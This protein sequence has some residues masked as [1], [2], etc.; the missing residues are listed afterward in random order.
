MKYEHFD[1]TVMVDEPEKSNELVYTEVAEGVLD[2]TSVVYEYIDPDAEANNIE[3]ELSFT[4]KPK[5]DKKSKKDFTRKR[6]PSE[7]MPILSFDTEYCKNP[8]GEGNR[9]LAYQ[10]VLGFGD[11]KN[12]IKGIIYPKSMKKSGRV[13]FDDFLVEVIE[14]GITA[15]IIDK[16]PT[17]IILCAHFLRADL[18]TFK[19]SF[20][21]IKTKIKGI[22][23]TV[24][25]LDKPYGVDLETVMKKRIDKESLKLWS[26][27][28]NDY[29]LNVTF[30]DTMLLA[31]AGYQS[32][33]AVGELVGV[34]KLEIPKPFSIERMDEYFKCDRA[35]AEEY[36]INDAVI[37]YL[38]MK[39][40]IDFCKELKLSRVPFT[41]GGLAVKAC[42]K[43]LEDG[44]VE[45]VKGVKKKD[46]LRLFGFV[47]TKIE[48]WVEREDKPSGFI[49]SSHNVLTPSRMIYEQFAT[50]TYS[51]GRGE[52][53]H[54]GPTP[55]G[56]FNDFDIQSC[57]T[58]ILNI[59]RPLNYDA[60][61]MSKCVSDYFGD[62]FGLL[63]VSFKFPKSVKFPS[64][65]V[66][67]EN[68]T[69]CFP[70]CGLSYCTAAE[71]EVAV[72]LDAEIEIINGIIIPW[73]NDERIFEPFMMHVR[74]RRRFYKG[75]GKSFEEKLW[76]EIGNSLYG[77]LAQGL[78]PKT[79]FDV[80]VGYSKQMPASV[81][82]NPYFAS[83]VTGMARAVLAEQLN[84]IPSDK[85]VVSVTTDGFLT[86][87]SMSD[88]DLSGPACNR[89]RDLFHL[90]DEDKGDILEVKHGATQL[91]GMKTRGQLTAQ[92]HED[93][94]PVIAKANV[95]LPQDV[96]DAHTYMVDLYLDR[97]SG[98]KHEMKMLTSS[99]DMF[100]NDKDLGNTTIKQRLNL[101][102]DYKRR[103]TNPH[104]V[105][106][107]DGRE[108]IALDSEPFN[109]IE[110]QMFTRKRFDV[111]RK[112]KC[113]KT[114]ADWDDW[115]EKLSMYTASK[116]K[117]VRIQKGETS[118]D[119]MCRLFLRGFAQKQWGLD[120]YSLTSKDLA[121][122]FCSHEYALTDAA[123]RGAKRSKLVEGAIPLTE[124]TLCLLRLL[125]AKFPKFK[126][127]ALFAP[128]A[129]DEL[130]SVMK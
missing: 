83:I 128:N 73:L 130:K 6:I 105:K 60:A 36:A 38:H 10:Y 18:F 122:W 86:N 76:K 45:R 15:K 27:S 112:N 3:T 75:S 37:S 63:R 114:I 82:T 17:D 16:W 52:N 11:L 5:L 124:Q 120:S 34:S 22:R 101:E 31:P 67:T 125:K 41:L 102:P 107:A 29:H 28:G 55:I 66:R 90:I 65:P 62:V 50:E 77:K 104:I 20:S 88:I 59:L 57:Y 70:S 4:G 121:A 1:P 118:G 79:A 72:N 123:V 127:E 35:G 117:G 12:S 2:S 89:F 97:E 23:K 21:N 58:A 69:L 13:S 32:L 44:G 46:Y 93:F 91:I 119:L 51:G 106:L 87:A 81:F 9:I 71:I 30:Y 56:F 53:Y 100:L 103:L 111:W 126:Y 61:V 39:L 116:A 92:S 113:L 80:Q 40:M 33:K 49:T 26:T 99:R 14:G 85:M 96:T 24:A 64:L 8:D 74:E 110:E 42:T 68:N 115:Q 54:T 43:S 78:R 129:H 7:K 25:S 19:D 98:Q 108:H 84:S 94:A 95:K 109:T 47:P 48:R